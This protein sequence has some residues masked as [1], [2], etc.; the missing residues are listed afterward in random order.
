M[1]ST[2]RMLMV[3]GV[4]G[5]ATPALAFS[6]LTFFQGATPFTGGTAGDGGSTFDLTFT[7]DGVTNDLD[8]LVIQIEF[9]TFDHNFLID[10]NLGAV[11]NLEEV[12]IDNNDPIAFTPAVAQPRLP[13]GNGLPRL[14]VTLT[15]AGI[16]FQA[17]TGTGS[18]SLVSVAYPLATNA[19]L[20]QDGLNTIRIQNPDSTGADGIDFTIAGTIPEPGTFTLVALGLVGLA[21]TS[22]RR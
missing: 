17:T 2:L 14:I 6:N 11:G 21:H 7:V 3:L 19:P 4:L 20:F 8:D 15:Q 10:V 5:F 16:T 18:N 9:L 22:R 12:P 1:T 13:N